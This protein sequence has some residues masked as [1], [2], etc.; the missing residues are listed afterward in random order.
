MRT[1]FRLVVLMM[2][3]APVVASCSKKKESYGERDMVVDV[4]LPTVDSV[5]LQDISR[6]SECVAVCGSRGEG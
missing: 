3:G 6:L 4:A 5:V 2:L 1:I